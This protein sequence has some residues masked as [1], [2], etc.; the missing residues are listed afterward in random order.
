[1]KTD[2]DHVLLKEIRQ[3][4]INRID[5]LLWTLDE[6]AGQRLEPKDGNDVVTG[7]VETIDVLGCAEILEDMKDVLE[8]K[9]RETSEDE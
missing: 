1:M 5:E 6:L 8:M 4:K 2:V 9:L 7:I 3:D